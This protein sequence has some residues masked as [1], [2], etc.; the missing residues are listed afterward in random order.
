MKNQTKAQFL[1][2]GLFVMLICGPVLADSGLST[3][4]QMA[5]LG[6]MCDETTSARKDR[7]N[8]ES[9]YSRLGGYDKILNFTTELVRLHL[10]NPAISPMLKGVDCDLLARHVADFTAAGTGGTANYTGRPMVAAHAHLNLTDAD[11]LSAGGDVV[12][13][14]QNMGYQQNEIDEFVCIL[15]SLKDQVVFK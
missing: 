10:E 9:L 14:M 4:E 12:K 5:G 11:F 13:A 2:T 8:H 6:T 15:V 3:A 1:T 7:Q